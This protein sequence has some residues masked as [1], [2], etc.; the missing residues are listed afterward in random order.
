V[1]ASDHRAIRNKRAQIR[2]FKCVSLEG[3]DI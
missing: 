3:M 1:S 2:K